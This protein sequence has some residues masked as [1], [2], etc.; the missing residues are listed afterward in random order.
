M[1]KF[2]RASYIEYGANTL[3]DALFEEYWGERVSKSKRYFEMVSES[4]Y[5][6]QKIGS[7][8]EVY[9]IAGRNELQ[10]LDFDKLA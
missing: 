9:F 5:F 10:F 6:C 2:I 1:L 3:E 4:V 8:L 7:H